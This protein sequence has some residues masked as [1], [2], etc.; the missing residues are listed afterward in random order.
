VISYQVDIVV[1]KF[2]FQIQLAPL[3][4]GGFSFV[5]ILDT[6]AGNDFVSRKMRELLEN[7]G[8]DPN[9]PPPAIDKK[10]LK[11]KVKE[12]IDVASK[13]P[14]TIPVGE[15]VCLRCDFNMGPEGIGIS[16]D[17]TYMS[18]TPFICIK[19]VSASAGIE[20][21]QRIIFD[22]GKHCA[23][24]DAGEEV[25]VKGEKKKLTVRTSFAVFVDAAGVGLT[26]KAAATLEES[27]FIINPMWMFPKVR[28]C[29]LNSVDP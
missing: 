13:L 22:N 1:S 6:M 12:F 4:Q 3:H 5:I 15:E 27:D 10:T 9:Q 23:D 25:C 11:T 24:N 19:G 14:L 17:M 2:A 7:L 16:P 20:I 29:K 18:F 28:R 26:A 8:P 21:K